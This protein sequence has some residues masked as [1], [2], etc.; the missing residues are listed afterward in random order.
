MKNVD[1][2]VMG[3]PLGRTCVRGRLVYHNQGEQAFDL[4]IERPFVRKA[5]LESNNRSERMFDI[6][7]V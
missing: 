4:S 3:S 2:V 6:R 1:C 7:I 5:D